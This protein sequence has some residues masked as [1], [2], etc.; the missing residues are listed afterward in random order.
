MDLNQLFARHQ[1]SL[2]RTRAAESPEARHAHAGLTRGYAARI[3][4][5]QADTGA[6]SP[7]AGRTA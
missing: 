7:L 4:T 3:A 5:L 1:I 2:M 6:T